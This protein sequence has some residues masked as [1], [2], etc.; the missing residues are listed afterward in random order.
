MDD[1]LFDELPEDPQVAFLM[2]EGIFHGELEEA[3]RGWKGDDFPSS[4]Y[5]EYMSKTLSAA[6]ELEL[7]IFSNWSTPIVSDFHYHTYL[8]FRKM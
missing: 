7:D 8:N 5:T 3:E 1:L 4:Y 2:L 6:S